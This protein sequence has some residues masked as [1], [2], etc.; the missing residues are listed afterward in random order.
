MILFWHLVLG[1]LFFAY[2]LLRRSETLA[3][4]EKSKKI[5]AINKLLKNNKAITSEKINDQNSKSHLNPK[6]WNILTYII[7]YI[8]FI[9]IAWLLFL[10]TFGAALIIVYLNPK[11][12]ELL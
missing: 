2:F 11:I 6:K 9:S 7:F 8:Q 4:Y 1:N 10:S 12:K 5:I 3:V